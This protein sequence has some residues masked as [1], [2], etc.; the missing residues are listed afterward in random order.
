M[1]ALGD[2]RLL[3]LLRPELLVLD[4]TPCVLSEDHP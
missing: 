4:S 3:L 1:I 2:P